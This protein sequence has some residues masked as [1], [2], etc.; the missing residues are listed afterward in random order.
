[1]KKIVF[2]LSVV[3]LFAACSSTKESGSTKA[4]NKNSKKLS[5]QAD[6]KKAVES[7]KYIIKVS[8]LFTTGGK[9]EL[10]PRSNFVIV[11]G[12]IASISLGYVGR[13]YYSRPIS[14][15]NLNGHT[16]NYQ[17]ESDEA[18]G[19]Y[20]V[21]MEVLYGSDK[22]YVYMTI[23]NSGVSSISINNSNIETANYSGN[24]VPLAETKD[25]QNVN[26]DKI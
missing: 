6:I 23:G 5:E 24:L 20:K 2:F 19:M 13:T 18:K 22:F 9:M 15:I 25:A 10:V 7:R 8:R 17:M 21:Q 16:L 3:F 4:E 12:E 1:M 26:G 11:N 14:G